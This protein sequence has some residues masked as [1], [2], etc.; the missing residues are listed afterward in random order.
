M[1]SRI[2]SSHLE[3]NQE[4]QI[5]FDKNRESK[6]IYTRQEEKGLIDGVAQTNFAKKDGNLVKVNFQERI[7]ID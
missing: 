6:T 2:R 5:K 1:S 3:Q 7:D 4:N